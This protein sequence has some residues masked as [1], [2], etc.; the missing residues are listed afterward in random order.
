MDGRTESPGRERGSDARCTHP[1][2]EGTPLNCQQPLGC[3]Q[4]AILPGSHKKVRGGPTPHATMRRRRGRGARLRAAQDERAL[5]TSQNER[6][7]QEDD[8]SDVGTVYAVQ[9]GSPLMGPTLLY[10]EPSK[11]I[12]PGPSLMRCPHEGSN[13]G[14]ISRAKRKHR[15]GFDAPHGY[16]VADDAALGAREH[17]R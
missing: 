5:R 15:P 16:P 11:T 4:Q 3:C 6:N 8:D 1:P 17:L 9:E 14:P 7:S 12:A 13:A 2:R 10:D